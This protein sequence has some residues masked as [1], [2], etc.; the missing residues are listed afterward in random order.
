MRICMGE[1]TEWFLRRMDIGPLS[2]RA[3]GHKTSMSGPRP[4]VRSPLPFT[5][6]E[7]RRRYL[8]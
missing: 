2:S 4:L 5:L 7:M 3:R 6:R 1:A 8:S